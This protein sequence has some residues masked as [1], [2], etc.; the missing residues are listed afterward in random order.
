MTPVE[1]DALGTVDVPDGVDW[2][3]RT[4]RSLRT[5]S[6]SG[7][8]LG[9]QPELVVA[10][11]QVKAAAARANADAGAI[12]AAEAAAIEEATEDLQRLDVELLGQLPAD[13]LAGGGA[14]AVH[15][16]VD[17]VLARRSGLD[18]GLL[19]ASQS[20]ADV[21]H[22]A[23]RLAVL[24]AA[25]R[26]LAAAAALEAELADVADRAGYRPTLARTCL[27]DGLAVP[28][29]VLWDG[30]ATAVRRRADAVVQAT[31]PLH[32]V[33]LGG[34]VVGT[35]DGAPDPYRRAVVPHLAGITERALVSDPDPA[36]RLQ[37]ADDLVACAD[38]GAALASVAAK[39]AR[40]LRLLASG[41]RG[42]F[43]EV[44]LPAV[45]EG[46]AFFVGKVN[47]AVPESVV[48]ASIQATGHA[49][50]ARAAAGQAELH[51]GVYDLAA[52]LA[53]IDQYAMVA[54]ALEHLV[55][56][57]LADLEFDQERAAEL[58]ALATPTKDAPEGPR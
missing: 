58:A 24:D 31:S 9:D 44:R 17:E 45:M 15:V 11:G 28:G 8:R 26:L 34:T 12:S 7:R 47:P 53:V 6:F 41:P 51:L 40:D 39:V 23:A 37:H 3:P 30:A 57:C 48:Q 54:T 1:R 5:L 52:G 50:V 33:V 14:I 2:G 42:G 22:T 21:V 49:A 36:S 10:L 43:G 13:P 35:G 18:L 38:A 20:T 46:S 29:R 4:W 19:R 16:N 55:T 32:E 56:H 25:D 27:Q